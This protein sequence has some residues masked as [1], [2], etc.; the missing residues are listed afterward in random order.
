M[1]AIGG[2]GI[3]NVRNAICLLVIRFTIPMLFVR[4]PKVQDINVLEDDA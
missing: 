3:K 4:T 2:S 1:T